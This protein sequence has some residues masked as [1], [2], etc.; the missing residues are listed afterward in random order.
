MGLLILILIILLNLSFTGILVAD[1]TYQVPDSLMSKLNKIFED[2][3]N[4]VQPT[5][6]RKSHK[7]Q[8]Y[9]GPYMFMAFT[10]NNEAIHNLIIADLFDIYRVQKYFNQVSLSAIKDES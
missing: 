2:K 8:N 1:T 7:K 4:L 9:Q 10:D 6:F 3:S 5:E